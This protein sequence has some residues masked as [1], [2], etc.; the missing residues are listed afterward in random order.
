MTMKTT[1]TRTVLSENGP[2]LDGGLTNNGPDQPLKLD[3][4]NEWGF[5]DNDGLETSETETDDDDADANKAKALSS[6][7]NWTS[8][9]CRKLVRI[10]KAAKGAASK[11]LIDFIKMQ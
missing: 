7:G 5:F 10:V 2:S 11:P 6:P 3:P 9:G 4:D 8:W 1:A